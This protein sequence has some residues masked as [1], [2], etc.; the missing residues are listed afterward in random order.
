MR[1]P[2][3]SVEMKAVYRALC[4]KEALPAYLC[5]LKFR[6][7]HKYRKLKWLT[8]RALPQAH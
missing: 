4:I 8:S 2:E 3:A 1:N 5:G 7:H 6:Y